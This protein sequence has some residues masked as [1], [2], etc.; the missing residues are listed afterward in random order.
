MDGLL[1]VLAQAPHLLI[2][3]EPRQ[4][5]V[6]IK[7]VRLQNELTLALNRGAESPDYVKTLALNLAA[8]RYSRH[9]DPTPAHELEQLRVRLEQGPANAD[10]LASLLSTAVWAVRLTP[11]KNVELE[12]VNG[13][14]ITDAKEESA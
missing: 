5:G 9:P 14:I 10:T 13:G 11:E 7:A 6:D 4:T 8:Q 1:R 2:I 3:P 12:L